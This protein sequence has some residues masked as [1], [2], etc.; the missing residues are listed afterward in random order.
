MSATAVAGWPL[1]AVAGRVVL[2][3]SAGSTGTFNLNAGMLTVDD[4][5][6]VGPRGMGILALGGGMLTGSGTL[7]VNESH[8]TLRG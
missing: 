6:E 7:V 2:G 3:R 5:V 1:T 4:G 8:G